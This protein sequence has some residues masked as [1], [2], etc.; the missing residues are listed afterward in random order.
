MG[1]KVV[2][3]GLPKK[4]SLLIMKPTPR[5]EEDN[6]KEAKPVSWQTPSTA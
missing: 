6:Y 5:S 4:V 3:E 2:F 1:G